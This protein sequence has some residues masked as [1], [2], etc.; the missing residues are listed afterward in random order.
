PQPAPPQP[1]PPQPAPPQPAPPP[2][3]PQ[4][5]PAEMIRDNAR[6]IDHARTARDAARAGKCEVVTELAPEVRALDP[7]F[8]D[9]L[10]AV[11]PLIAACM[12]VAG[13]RLVLREVRADP[14]PSVKRIGGEILLG[15]VVGTG[16]ALVGALLGS[17]VCKRSS[18]GCFHA[19]IGSAYVGGIVTIPL[20]IQA[21]GASGD[22]T[23][24]LGA[25]YLG[26]LIGGLGGL[27]M[28]A[29][30][31]DEITALGLLFAPPLGAMIGFNA[32]RRYKPRRVRVRVSASLVDWSSGSGPSLGV[33]IPARV[34]SDDRTVT[35]IPLLG[36]TF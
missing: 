1:A 22:Q 25:A 5:P 23:G 34:R 7:A 31:H 29:N 30:G 9:R 12:A 24:S 4:P 13:T 21:V 27:L 8:H 19:R 11:D 17:G 18:R 26:S 33:P 36:G 35:S 16:G 32:T 10:F 28:I 20:G 2:Q 14:P 6:L 15:M 3:R